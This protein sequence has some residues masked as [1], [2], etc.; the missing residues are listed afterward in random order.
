MKKETIKGLNEKLLNELANEY[1]DVFASFTSEEV[2]MIKNHVWSQEE[3]DE[4][5][6]KILEKAAKN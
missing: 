1:A 5:T 2:N 3:E 4:I 6:R